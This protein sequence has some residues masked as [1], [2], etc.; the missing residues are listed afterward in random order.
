MAKG[1]GEDLFPPTSES[2]VGAC[3]G[4]SRDGRIKWP[5]SATERVSEAEERFPVTHALSNQFP[6]WF[7]FT[8][9]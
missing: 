4:F 8:D 3:V 2:A 1:G 7:G 5:V 6:N 9:D